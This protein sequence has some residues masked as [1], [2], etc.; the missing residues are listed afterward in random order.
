MRSVVFPYLDRLEP[1]VRNEYELTS[2]FDMMLA[3][4]L[5]LRIAAIDGAWR[6]V[7]RPEDLAALNS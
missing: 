5:E 7:G 1:S 4:S 6:D 3:D 2:I